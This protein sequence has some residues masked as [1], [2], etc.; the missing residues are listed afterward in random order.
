MLNGGKKAS[1]RGLFDHSNWVTDLHG[2]YIVKKP[3]SE[4]GSQK[5]PISPE[6]GSNSC[7]E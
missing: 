7:V 5:H 6:L 4:M 2:K 1:C 3:L